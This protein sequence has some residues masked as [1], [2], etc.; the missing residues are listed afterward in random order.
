V[1]AFEFSHKVSGLTVS[2]CVEVAP[3]SEA[4]FLQGEEWPV[5]ASRCSAEASEAMQLAAQHEAVVLLNEATTRLHLCLA[6][7]S[8]ELLAEALGS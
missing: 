5:T 2:L 7:K 4:L 1:I 3:E 8:V 6:Q